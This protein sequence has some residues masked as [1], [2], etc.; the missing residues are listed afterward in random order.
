[1]IILEFFIEDKDQE[2]YKLTLWLT[3]KIESS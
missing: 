1:M 3:Y 2:S